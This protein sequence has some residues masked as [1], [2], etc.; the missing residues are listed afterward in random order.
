MNELYS[1]GSA[2]RRRLEFLC[3]CLASLSARFQRLVVYASLSTFIYEHNFLIRFPTV[4]HIN[5][6]RFCQMHTVSIS[7]VWKN[8]V[9]NILLQMETSSSCEFPLRYSILTSK[10]DV[11]CLAGPQVEASPLK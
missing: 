11:L 9:I 2:N 1:I 4:H 5:G 10:F 8:S 6:V 7:E 3:D